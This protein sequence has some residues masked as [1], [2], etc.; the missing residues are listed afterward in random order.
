[1]PT[2]TP[3]NVLGIWYVVI[4]GRR[5]IAIILDKFRVRSTWLCPSLNSSDLI[6][7]V[8]VCLSCFCLIDVLIQAVSVLLLLSWIK[9]SYF[10]CIDSSCFSLTSSVLVQA[11]LLLIG[12]QEAQGEERK[13]WERKR[14]EKRRRK[15]KWINNSVRLAFVLILACFFC[16]ALI[17]AWFYLSYFCLD[18][19]LLLLSYLDAGLVLAWFCLS[20]FCFISVLI[21]VCFFWLASSVLILSVLLLSCIEQMG[22]N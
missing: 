1:M 16:L 3:K 15:K 7:A 22:T 17:L 2:I 18:S 19:G 5:V 4:F 14:E 9:L 11:V 13:E 10:W 21:Q 12:R 8:S 6:Q 20:Y